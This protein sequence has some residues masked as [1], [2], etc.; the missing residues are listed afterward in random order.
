M[1]LQHRLA[2]AVAAE[3]I[4]EPDQ[5]D[6]P[7]GRGVEHGLIC[8]NELFCGRIQVVIDTW[9][10][11]QQPPLDSCILD[12]VEDRLERR[13]R[14]RRLVG[15]DFANNDRKIGAANVPAG[16][17]CDA[18]VERVP[19]LDGGEIPERQH[20]FRAVGPRM[21]AESDVD[22]EL[23]P[24]YRAQLNRCGKVGRNRRVMWGDHVLAPRL[25]EP[26]PGGIEPAWVGK[27]PPEGAPSKAYQLSEL[28]RSPAA[29]LRGT[30]F[31]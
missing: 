3:C 30:G 19:L 18:P 15:G 28:T 24:E 4:E 20:D 7:K 31:S 1:T 5:T 13:L 9:I 29:F 27:A 8:D 6:R 17:M 16:L 21:P 25:G 12:D 22:P 11:I 10:L 14:F 2:E 26:T 23:T